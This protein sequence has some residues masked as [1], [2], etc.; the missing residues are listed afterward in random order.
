LS[1]QLNQ[2][3]VMGRAWQ[4]AWSNRKYRKFFYW[5]T[6]WKDNTRRTEDDT[7]SL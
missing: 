1:E 7:E 6:S 4:C 3:F 5:K 2:R